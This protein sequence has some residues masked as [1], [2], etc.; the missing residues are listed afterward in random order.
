MQFREKLESMKS[1]IWKLINYCGREVFFR[2]EKG[3][4]KKIE[5]ERLDLRNNVV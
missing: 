5:N 2:G 1:L 3:Q 4:D